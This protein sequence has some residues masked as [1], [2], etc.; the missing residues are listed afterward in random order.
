[1]LRD[2]M[3]DDFERG[4]LGFTPD[5]TCVFSNWLGYLRPDDPR[6]A[7]FRAQALGAR[8]EHIHTSG[9]A[10][11]AEIS[12]FALAI[13]PRAVVPVHGLAWDDPQIE[14]PPVRRLGDG[15]PWEIP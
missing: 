13:A 12:R 5:D 3:L 15:E 2:P 10:S 1:M 14:L 8:V 9:H 11:P 4:G 7:W 6:T